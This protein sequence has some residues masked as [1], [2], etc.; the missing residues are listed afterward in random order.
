MFCTIIEFIRTAFSN[1]HVFKYITNTFLLLDVCRGWFKVTFLI[2]QMGAV[3]WNLQQPKQG[4]L[5]KKKVSVYSICM[6]YL[7][8]TQCYFLTSMSMCTSSCKVKTAFSWLMQLKISLA[9]HSELMV[10]CKDVMDGHEH[11][12]CVAC[13]VFLPSTYR[14]Q[15]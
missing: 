15:Q 14:P 6:V 4:S 11:C 10:A 8:P 3:C 9:W 12:Q 7:K 5:P 13:T 2:Y 1:Q